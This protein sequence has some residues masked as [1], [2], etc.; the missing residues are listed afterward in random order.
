LKILPLITFYARL[1]LV[2]AITF[3]LILKIAVQLFIIL[4]NDFHFA[5]FF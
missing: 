2:K 4:F 1:L 5:K 3:R